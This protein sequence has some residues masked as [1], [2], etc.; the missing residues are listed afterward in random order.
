VTA[1]IDLDP[2]MNLGNVPINSF[3]F[4]KRTKITYNEFLQR[5]S[6]NSVGVA[7]KDESEAIGKTLLED[8]SML[9]FWSDINDISALEVI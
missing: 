1:Y 2:E 4:N 3:E 6:E 5:M 8:I 9:S 7:M